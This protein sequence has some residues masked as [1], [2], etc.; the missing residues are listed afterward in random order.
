M[1]NVVE[2]GRQ[3]QEV[4]R[5]RV[6]MLATYALSALVGS[7]SGLF[8]LMKVEAKMARRAIGP[9]H[10]GLVHHEAVHPSH[11]SDAGTAPLELLVLGDSSAAGYGMTSTYDAPPGLLASGLAHIAGRAVHVRSEAFVGA[12]SSALM[13][14]LERAGIPT[15]DVCVVV[16][17]AND[18]THAVRP[19]AAADQLGTLVRRLTDEGVAV[20]VGT[21]PDLGTITPLPQPLRLVARIWARQL[22]RAQTVAVARAGGRAVSLGSLL[23]ADFYAAPG[24]LFGSD[25]FH[26][27][28]AGYASM[29]A[30]LLPSVAASLGYVDEDDETAH[31][32]LLPISFGAARAARIA[33]SETVS[34][35]TAM[36]DSGTG[37]RVRRRNV[38]LVRVL[39]RPRLLTPPLPSWL[40]E[41]AT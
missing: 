1:P 25:R 36:T 34:A 39:Q 31:A 6:S 2:P 4:R 9:A 11:V 17:G 23:G 13:S 3:Q 21:C 22:A 29:C 8:W 16:V 32:G 40:R 41:Q 37:S 5:R 18:V 30:A 38:A 14:Q 10:L 28:L 27:S 15:P 20:V 24:E 26:P 19:G 35:S 33:G 12:R 7:G